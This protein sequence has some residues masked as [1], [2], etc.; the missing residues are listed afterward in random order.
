MYYDQFEKKKKNI[1]NTRVCIIFIKLFV[2]IMIDS[3]TEIGLILLCLRVYSILIYSK[4]QNML[5]YRVLD[6]M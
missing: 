4:R 6:M 2:R 1:S 5:Y 3:K